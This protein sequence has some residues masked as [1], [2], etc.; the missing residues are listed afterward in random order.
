MSTIMWVILI[1]FVEIFFVKI[2]CEG[3][4]IYLVLKVKELV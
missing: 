1:K 2:E 3:R 4:A